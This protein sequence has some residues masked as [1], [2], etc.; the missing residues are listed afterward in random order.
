MFAR[1]SNFLQ[2]KPAPAA[3]SS[4]ASNTPAT[5][6]PKAAASTPAAPQAPAQT[7][8]A[9]AAVPATPTPAGAGVPST[10]TPASSTLS[11]PAALNMVAERQAAVANLESMGFER[12]QIDA[13]MRAAFYNADRA[14]EYLL[15]VS[16]D[17]RLLCSDIDSLLGHSREHSTA[18]AASCCRSPTSTYG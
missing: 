4:T 15:N 13:A 3:S 6:A 17:D 2:A 10:D 16:L 12:T 11:D 14:V 18:T 7:S 1:F 8:N 9:A 5:P